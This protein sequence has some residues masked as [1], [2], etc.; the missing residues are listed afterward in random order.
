MCLDSHSADQS[1][2]KPKPKPKKRQPKPM[3]L[4]TKQ[5]VKTLLA[6]TSHVL[7]VEDFDPIAELDRAAEVVVFGP[8]DKS[9]S[10]YAFPLLYGG[11][12]F[13][14]PTIGKQMYWQ[15]HVS[16]VVD[17]EW[18]TCAYLWLLSQSEVPQER[19]KDVLKAIKKWAR[20]C[21]LTD[22]DV[23]RI[24]STYEHNGDS[25]CV[26]NVEILS[27]ILNKYGKDANKW[28]ELE[29]MDK[30]IGLYIESKQPIRSASYGEI[31]SLLVREYGQD[32]NHW[33]N[34]PE[35][36][37]A[38]LLAD[39][40]RRQEDKAAAYRRSKAGTKNPLPPLPSPKFKAS[41]HYRELK[42]KLRDS[43]QKS[44]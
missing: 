33:L 42:Q 18:L 36:E 16:S 32:C 29:D 4:M 37:I 3:Q 25:I 38:M 5:D 15:E 44:A 26:G 19:G 40:T 34:A 30:Q 13:Y 14:A 9:E 21:K 27:M 43:W 23:K 1:K 10:V 35:H 41:K 12:A 22:D 24:V 20:K 31:I 11:N 8:K 7:T 6:E 17:D 39:W 2:S 28:P